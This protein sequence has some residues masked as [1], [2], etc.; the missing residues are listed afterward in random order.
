MLKIAR[1]IAVLA[2]ASALVGADFEPARFRSGEL[3]VQ[4]VQPPMAGGGRVLLELHIDA[5]GM[6]TNVTTLRS[7]PPLSGLL[8]D[9]VSQWRF[10]P[11]R[12]THEELEHLVP[13]ESRV[14]VT[15]VF[16]PPTLY[17]APARGE[18]GEEVASASEEVPFPTSITTPVYPPT[19]G[20]HIGQVVLVEAEVGDD[21]S[22]TDAR[23]LRSPAGFQV[24]SLDAARK[25]KFRPARREGRAVTSIVYIVFGFREPVVS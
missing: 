4:A 8:A 2:F 12:A 5:S 22:V 13:V 19:A 23:V 3:P 6:V 7:T 14:L 25:W 24:V 20:P 11:A 10:A 21:G 17:D 1:H 9:A 15:G 18:V 16:R